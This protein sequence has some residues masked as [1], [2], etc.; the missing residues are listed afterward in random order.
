MASAI[1]I[2]DF[3]TRERLRKITRMEGGKTAPLGK[4]INDES[5]SSSN[6]S[7]MNYSRKSRVRTDSD[8][9]IQISPLPVILINEESSSKARIRI[10]STPNLLVAIWTATKL[11]VSLKQAMMFHLSL[12][13]ATKLKINHI[14]LSMMLAIRYQIP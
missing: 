11:K 6:S 1:V 14:N 5:L 3:N 2:N 4:P 13:L 8:S 9:G 12:L 10:C 7:A